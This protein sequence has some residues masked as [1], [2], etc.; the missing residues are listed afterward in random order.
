MLNLHI[1]IYKLGGRIQLLLFG[2]QLCFSSINPDCQPTKEPIWWS[3]VNAL[4]S[5]LW[6]ADRVLE[7]CVWELNWFLRDGFFFFWVWSP[8]FFFCLFEHLFPIK[9]FIKKNQ[10]TLYLSESNFKFSK[11]PGLFDKIELLSAF[12]F[13]TGFLCTMHSNFHHHFKKKKAW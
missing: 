9:L 4:L 6:S 2:Q 13:Y 10:N 3:L 1:Y 12:F 8:P 5:L 7:L 11:S